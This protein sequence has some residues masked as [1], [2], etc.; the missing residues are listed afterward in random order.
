MQHHYAIARHETGE[1]FIRIDIDVD[2]DGSLT[3]S[4]YCRGPAAEQ[5]FGCRD[6][7]SV[8]R[9]SPKSVFALYEALT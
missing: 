8:V 2:D 6:I 5:C 1:N 9:L 3:M 4:D 7:E